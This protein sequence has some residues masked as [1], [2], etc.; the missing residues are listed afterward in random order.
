M[1]EIN[2][3]GVL[4]PTEQVHPNKKETP[5]RIENKFYAVCKRWRK[6]LNLLQGQII[7]QRNITVLE[8]ESHVLEECMAEL[9]AA[10]EALENIQSSTVEKMTLYGKFEDMSRETN[11]ILKQVGQTI[12]ELKREDED[13]YS[14][15]SLRSHRSGNSHKSKRSKSSRSSLASTSSSARLRRLNLEEEIASL[16]VKMNMAHEKEQLDKANRLAL[17]EIE[18]QKLEVQKEE[19]RLVEEIKLAKERFEIKEQLAEKEARFEACTRFENENT[20]M[21]FDDGDQGNA[22]QEHIERFLRSQEPSLIPPT[23][24]NG[25]PTVYL[26][27]KSFPEIPEN[28][29]TAS[30]TRQLNPSAPVCERNATAISPPA[31]ILQDNSVPLTSNYNNDLTHVPISTTNSDLVQTQLLAIAKLLEAQNQ[32][33]LPLPEPGVAILYNTQYG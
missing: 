12:Y 4:D 24:E 16:R 14:A 5:C 18:K 8:K 20:S 29:Q 33:R 2:G 30:L 13:R 19:Q 9:A 28:C 7:S 11:E 27:Q 32:N 3:A 21:I 17:N 31:A 1:D 26:T 15:S 23:G 22:A 6:Q 10:Q 25:E